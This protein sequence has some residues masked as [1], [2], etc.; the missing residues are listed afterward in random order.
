MTGA[1][2]AAKQDLPAIQDAIGQSRHAPTP[3]RRPGS[4]SPG[5]AMIDGTI[6]NCSSSL[7]RHTSDTEVRHAG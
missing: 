1:A 5:V 6:P 4:C 2:A 3:R 7:L